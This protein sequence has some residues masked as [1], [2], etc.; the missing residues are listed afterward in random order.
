MCHAWKSLSTIF[1]LSLNMCFLV[2]LRPCGK[3]TLIMSWNPVLNAAIKKAPWVLGRLCDKTIGVLKPW[4]AYP[5]PQ[6]CTDWTL[7]PTPTPS[8]SHIRPLWHGSSELCF[9]IPEPIH[10]FTHFE[11][12]KWPQW[13]LGPDSIGTSR[14][15]KPSGIDLNDENYCAQKES[16]GAFQRNSI[17]FTK[18]LAR[19]S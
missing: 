6:A 7:D 4:N 2:L 16:I 15:G 12:M 9:L 17:L 3:L 11:T 5:R 19:Q 13:L 10:P 1:A 18:G 14:E 8:T